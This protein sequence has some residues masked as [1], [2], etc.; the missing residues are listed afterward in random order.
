MFWWW[1]WWNCFPGRWSGCL[2]QMRQWSC[3]EASISA[4]ILLTVFLREFISVLPDISVHTENHIL[5]LS[6]IFC[7]FY[8]CV[9]RVLTLPRKCIRI[10]CFRWDL[11]HRQALFC[12]L[13]SAWE[14][15]SGCRDQCGE[16]EMRCHKNIIILT[17]IS[18]CMRHIIQWNIQERG[19]L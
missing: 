10:I 18:P 13:W 17:L 9:F 6:T 16:G 3:W 8:C 1:P 4:R 5:D 2:Q 7:Q 11:Q 19:D 15:T 12:R 14:R